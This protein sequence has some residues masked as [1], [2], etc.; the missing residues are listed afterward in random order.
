MNTRNPSSNNFVFSRKPFVT[1]STI[2][3]L[4][5]RLKQKD[6][7][8]KEPIID[9]IHHR[10]NRRYIQPL[11]NVT[12]GYESGFL[13]M[14]ASCLLIEALQ[15][16]YT[17]ENDTKKT[18]SANAFKA[19]FEREEKNGNKFFPGFAECF[20]IAVKVINGKPKKFFTFYRHIRCGILHQAETT[21]G[22]SIVRDKTQLFDA[23]EQTI[24]ADKFLKALKCYLDE[25]IKN[26]R[27]SE[28]SNDPWPMALK[29]IGH[30][31]DNCQS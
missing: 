14:A 19:F 13:I 1:E 23:K 18:G 21:G 11:L 26:L 6:Y 29:K 27:E 8:T 28:I 5:S 22:Y 24:E 20:P 15:S 7:T 25:Y 30:I 12:P 31:C 3:S 17:G 9:F 16:F 4:L 2:R 10:L